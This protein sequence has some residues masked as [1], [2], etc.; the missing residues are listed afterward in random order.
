MKNLG[1]GF[2]KEQYY[3][4][5]AVAGLSGATLR[6]PG[7]FLTAL[8]GGRNVVAITT[9][10]LL[11]PAV[12]L[13]LAL[14]DRGTSFSTFVVLATLSGFGGGAF[15]SSMSN[16]S[17]FFPKRMQGLA[18]GLN[19]GVGNLG[20]SVVQF[21][22]PY[23]VTVGL[24][25]SLGG[26]SSPVA[27]AVRWPSLAA[28]TPVWVQNCGL[29]WIPVLA[30]LAVAAWLR[31]DNLPMHGAPTTTASVGRVLWMNLLGLLAAGV[32]VWLLVTVGLSVWLVLPVTIALAMAGLR[33]IS[34]GPTRERV[35]AQLGVLKRGHCWV[36]TVLYVMT[37]GSF[38]GFSF[39]FA[40]LI[41][42]VFGKLPNGTPRP[43]APSPTIAFLGP[44]IGSLVRPVGG[45]LSDRFGGA[46]VTQWSTVL[47]IGA[48]IGLG[49]CFQKLRGSD[50]PLD[51]FVA[52]LVLFLL[53]FVTAGVGNGST[54]RMI[55]MIFQPT[56]AGPVLAWT[57][58]IAAYGSLVIPEVFK[59]Q[60]KAGTPDVAVFGFAAFYAVCL[61][62]NWWFYVRKGA[63]I[64]C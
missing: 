37:F 1:W 38:I 12:G 5:T 6:I 15:A 7:S 54:F 34:P 49:V 26:P 35:V 44:L 20:V 57:S 63:A 52:F 55:P 3:T 36:M 16:I 9:A 14:G 27:Q 53:L 8:S 19:A 50:A 24:F 56:E 62:L 2:Q 51:F 45:W 61:V 21:A 41:Q 46:R 64:R 29:V 60:M 43:G 18:L 23:A 11:I 48:A 13:G 17:F 32:G 42:D 40:L 59:G 39:V 25:G 4:L 58:A 10:L 28:G 30:V 47:M 22:L 33:Y 31:M